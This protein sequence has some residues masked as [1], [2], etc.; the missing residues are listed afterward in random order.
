MLVPFLHYGFWNLQSLL[1]DGLTAE[2]IALAQEHTNI[3]TLL[4]KMKTV[5]ITF[6][7]FNFKELNS[8]G[9]LVVRLTGQIQFCTFSIKS[10]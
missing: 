1:Q 4:A 7:G 2:I 8:G 9:L 10:H 3:G 6:S 5:S